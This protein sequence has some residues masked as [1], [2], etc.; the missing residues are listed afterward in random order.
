MS[1]DLRDDPTLFEEPPSRFFA[2]WARFLL[3]F[4]WALLVLTAAL[5]ALGGWL[6]A[7][8]IRVDTSIEAF[9]ATISPTQQVLE[10][11]RDEFGRDER[12]ILLIEGDVFSLP[13]LEKLKALHEELAALDMEVPSLGERRADR[14]RRRFG[15]DAPTKK[16]PEVDP[17][18]VAAPAGDAFGEDDVFA[19]DGGWGEVAGGSLVEETLSLLN[20]RRTRAVAGGIE[21]GELMDPFPTADQLPA[22]KA[23]VLA[24]R[25]LVGQLVDREGRFSVIALRTQFM[26]EA[27]SIRVNAAVEEIARKY[28]GPGFR[29][30]N[31]GLPELSAE[32]N[33]LM[34]S[35]LRRMFALSV[36]MML[37]MLTFLFRHPL[38]VVAPLGV[39]AMAAIG[40][41]AFMAVTG[42]PVTMLSNVLPAF[43][44][45][46]GLGDS[47]HLISVF[48]DYRKHGLDSREAVVM[49]VSTTGV[50][51][52]YT[53]LT[54]I[55]GLVSFEFATATAIQDMGGA[56]AFGVFLAMV[57]S[58]VFLP[59]CL[60]FNK[61]SLFGAREGVRNDFLDRF[62]DWCRNRS[63][64]EADDGTGPE[65][66]SARRRR[67]NTLLV[68]G[69]LM[70][71]AAV[72][73]SLV[74]VYHNPLSWM[75]D[76]VQIKQ[77]FNRMDAHVGGT[78]SI[79]LLIDGVPEK[80]I[81]DQALV[82]GLEKLQAHVEAYEHPVHGR[83]VGNTVSFIDVI[84]ETHQALQ[85]GDESF[86][87]L[88]D[89]ER[90]IADM[91]FMFENAGP[92]EL[93][94]FA[95]TDLSRG[96]M[97]F[98]IKWMDAQSYAPLTEHL[99]QGVERFI[100]AEARV[101]PTGAVYTLLSTVGGIIGDLIRSFGFAFLLITVIMTLL[102]RGVKMGLIAMVPN[103]LPI[104]LIMAF[105]GFAHIPVD[106]NN[107]L[108]ASIALG[109]AVDDTIHFMHH[110]RLGYAQ[111]G[112][113]DQAIR[114]SMR[115]SGRAMTSTSMILM[116]GFFSY[117]GAS[118][119]NIQ[120]FGLLIGLTV[121][122]AL[123]IDLIFTPALLRTFYPRLAAGDPRK[124]EKAHEVVEAQ[125]A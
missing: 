78:A 5:T 77:A 20:A 31:A 96:Q 40:T 114:R 7:T 81:K 38:A 84:K 70:G 26:N 43:L 111:S 97:T 119:Y 35:D 64:V 61:K 87:R 120:R 41:F 116:F 125:P 89:S 105:I 102:L 4:R 123:L 109:I 92:D 90:G 30:F 122:M 74:T 33:E 27:D 10:E 17:A 32:L 11:L 108:I 29:I 98:R 75:D 103:L 18:E 80:G 14:D 66:A 13:Y 95:A 100:P 16:R 59:I 76:E 71:A 112:N 113:M 1:A 121:V 82:E 85:G 12:Y 88:P 8:R 101:Q 68:G 52:A 91:L 72:G 65:P 94:R 39:V 51:M 42:M 49:A 73:I 44:F 69:A 2:A 48:R 19:D 47:V 110:V 25:T 107:V 57:H 115:H 55:V 46:V 67:R 117:M 56:G 99:Q 58:L 79:N 60:S 104:A 9:A 53:S 54:T 124:E 28:E 83:I 36:V 118:M 3:R 45:C 37:V 106:L 21:V 50:P 34:M 6:V 23:E 24:D 93:R 15:D 62:L 86:Y 22:L 63:G